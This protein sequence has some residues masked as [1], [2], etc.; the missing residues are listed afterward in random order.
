VYQLGALPEDVQGLL[1]NFAVAVSLGFDGLGS[2][3]RCSGLASPV[4]VLTFWLIVPYLITILVSA[5]SILWAAVKKRGEPAWFR[6]AV[7][8]S[9]RPAL[10]IAFG[11]YPIVASAAFQAFACEPLGDVS[12]RFLPPTYTLECGPAGQPT[13]EYERLTTVA[14]IAVMLY[15]VGISVFTAILLYLARK[16]LREGKTTDFTRAIGF[17]HA[18]YEP[19]FF[20]WELVEQLKKLVLVGLAVFVT[21]GSI[22]QLVF[23]LIFA[24]VHVRRFRGQ[25]S[26]QNPASKLLLLPLRRSSWH[27]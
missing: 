11:S 2:V 14:L 13:A 3:L 1:E 7:L 26:P 20:W 24:L 9:M 5:G 23:G 21:P 25:R 16:P 17:L 4:N 12:L 18:E 10:L 6:Q 19:Q 22:G 15:P 8:W 27:M